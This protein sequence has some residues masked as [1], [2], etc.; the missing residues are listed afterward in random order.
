VT[1]YEALS[2]AELLGLLAERDRVVVALREAAAARDELA[3][4]QLA[5]AQAQVAALAARVEQLERRLGKDSSTSSK[6]PSS[7]SPYQ[8]KSRDRSLRRRSGRKPG[9]QPGAPSSTLKQSDDP[10]ETVKCVPAACGCCGADLEG[11]PVTGVRRRQ[12][13][14]AAP[15]PPPAV[16]EYQVQ[17]KTCLRCGT[18]RPAWRRLVSPAWSSTG[19]QSTRTRRWRSAAITCRSAAPQ[20]WSRP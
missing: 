8:K 16:I 2:Q 17:D 3:A 11:A 12:V 7:D 13:F 15:P 1:G 9:K 4:A 14:E 5:V 6:P 18:M 19:R 10:G 20:T